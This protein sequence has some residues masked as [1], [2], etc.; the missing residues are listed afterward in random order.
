M[1]EK[2]T[3]PVTPPVTRGPAGV[4]GGREGSGTAGSGMGG[5]A[6]CARRR[7]SPGACPAWG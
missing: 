2:K 4:S 6:S 1:E 5:G 7:R 3:I